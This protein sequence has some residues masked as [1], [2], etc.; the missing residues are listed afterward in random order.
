MQPD[1]NVAP[2]A[3]SGVAPSA[4]CGEPPLRSDTAD[5]CSPV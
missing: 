3:S 4:R 2:D 5:L 1:A